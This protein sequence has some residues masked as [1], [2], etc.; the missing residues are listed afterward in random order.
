[1]LSCDGFKSSLTEISWVVVELKII[2]SEKIPNLNW[3]VIMFYKNGTCQLPR[4]KWN[5]DMNATWEYIKEWGNRF[6]VIKSNNIFNGK[7]VYYLNN[8]PITIF[9]MTLI[10]D[11]LEITCAPAAW[12]IVK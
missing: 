5:D 7:Y 3:N 1:M 10:S 6:V 11:S 2:K 12:S 4:I 9:K 8:D